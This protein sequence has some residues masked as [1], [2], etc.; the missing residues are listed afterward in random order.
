MTSCSCLNP[1]PKYH[2]RWHVT[3]PATTCNRRTTVRERADALSRRRIGRFEFEDLPRGDLL[4]DSLGGAFDLRTHYP[5]SVSGRRHWYV[6]GLFARP[7]RG[8]GRGRSRI[9]P[10]S[11]SGLHPVGVAIR[12]TS[13][14]R[15]GRSPIGW[16]GRS[17]FRRARAG[18]STV[19][20]YTTL[21]MSSLRYPGFK[22]FKK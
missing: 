4:I 14:N 1:S 7:A 3:D 9:P 17:S 8:C 22:R 5:W 16:I 2:A 10:K 11:H 6:C 12:D 15:S 13:L 20:T 19:T 18:P 21:S